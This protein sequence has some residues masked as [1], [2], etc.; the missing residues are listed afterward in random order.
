MAVAHPIYQVI[1]D[2]LSRQINDG[3][4]S[5]ETRI[6]SESELA[7]RYGVS[8]MTVRQAL[9]QMEDE[10]MVIRRRGAGTF[11]APAAAR[12]RT[13]NRL[14][15]FEQE[16]GLEASRLR[17]EIVR[18]ETR[19]P[20]DD[21]GERLMLKPRQEA[22]ML[23]RL[24]IIDDRPAALQ[25]S[26]IPYTA[27]PSLARDELIEGSLYRTLAERHGIVVQWAEQEISAVLA[28]EKRAAVLQVAV[29]DP[30]TANKRLTYASTG[31]IEFA[32][33]WT[34]SEYPLLIR[35]DA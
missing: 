32:Y 1:Y 15:P 13:L 12:Y 3:S 22:I 19:V 4:L 25:E 18:R 34:R 29:G 28:D 10:R 8:R 16:I 21:V 27:A 2:D 9:K 6:P 24:R 17:T 23:E 35:L 33:G 5:P 7:G 30:L 31:P 26:W 20:P 11:V 14:R